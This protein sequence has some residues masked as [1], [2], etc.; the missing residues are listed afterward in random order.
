MKI[1]AADAAAL[2]AV[3]YRDLEAMTQI[4]EPRRD[5]RKRG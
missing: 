4:E 1:G 3:L 5:C 2:A